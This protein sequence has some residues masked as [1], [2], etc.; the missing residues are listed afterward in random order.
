MSPNRGSSGAAATRAAVNTEGLEEA[1][2]CEEM[3]ERRSFAEEGE[4]MLK[5]GRS[6]YITPF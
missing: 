4:V 1:M 2:M 6:N 3:L 5:M